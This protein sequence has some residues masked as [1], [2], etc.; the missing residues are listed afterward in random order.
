MDRIFPE[1][2]NVG[3]FVR[4]V[5]VFAGRGE[6]IYSGTVTAFEDDYVTL[7]KRW[8][9]EIDVHTSVAMPEVLVYRIKEAGGQ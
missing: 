1:Q 4:I 2:I 6:R 8:L 5:Q 9:D 3:D 7:D